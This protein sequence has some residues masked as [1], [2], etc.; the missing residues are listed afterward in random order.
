MLISSTNLL[1]LLMRS[2]WIVQDFL[3]WHIHRDDLILKLYLGLSLYP[4]FILAI[5]LILVYICLILRSQN[6]IILTCSHVVCG[7][8]PF[9]IDGILVILD[10]HN[11]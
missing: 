1:Y 10:F 2:H 8:L 5:R 4:S 9:E 7:L 6:L 11:P 3:Q